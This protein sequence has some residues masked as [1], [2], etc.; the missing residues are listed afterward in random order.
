MRAIHGVPSE[1]TG[2]WLLDV[3]HSLVDKSL[4]VRQPDP[5]GEQR[6][7]AVRQAHAKYFLALGAI[8]EQQDQV[9]QGSAIMA[10]FPVEHDNLRAALSWALQHDPC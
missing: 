4:V 7:C 2:N 1:E 3:M 8:I 5:G 9:E 10:T 6:T